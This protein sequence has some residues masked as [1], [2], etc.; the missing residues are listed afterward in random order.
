MADGFERE[1]QQWQ[2]TGDQWN[3]K[4]LEEATDT[5]DTGLILTCGGIDWLTPD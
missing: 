5:N 1:R 4:R 2:W 3:K